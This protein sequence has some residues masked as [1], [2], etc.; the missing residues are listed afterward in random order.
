MWMPLPQQ[1]R[2]HLTTEVTRATTA[3]STLTTDLATEVTRATTAENTLITDLGT[4]TTRA[5]TAEAT[6]EDLANKSIDVSTDGTSDTKYPSVK[7]VKTY[8]DASSATGSTALTTEV[9]PH[10]KVLTT[11]LAQKYPSHHCRKYPNYRFR[12]RNNSSYNS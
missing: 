6:K 3:E 10:A 9:R 8:V 7:S 4:E 1:G 12:N 11:D 2:Q 5:T